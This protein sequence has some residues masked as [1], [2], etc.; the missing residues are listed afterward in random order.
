MSPLPAAPAPSDAAPSDATPPSLPERLRLAPGRTA[1]WRSPSCLQLGLDPQRALVLEGLP[2]PLAVLLKRMDGVR[3]TTELLAEAQAA[4]SSRDDALAMLADLHGSGLVRDAG[5]NL[6][7]IDSGQP[8]WHRIALAS[9][10]ASWSVHTTRT[11]RDV[12]GRRRAAAVQ[13]VGSGRMAVALATALAAAGVGQVTVQASGT[14]G[15][16]DVDTG[17]LPDDLA[18]PA[19]QRQPTPCVAARPGCASPRAAGQI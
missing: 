18:G 16:A 10:A 1:L 15:A 7:A 11:T 3:S 8:G 4:G 9:E 19:R 12:L 2:E 17:Y 6:G 14:V 5:T 13:V